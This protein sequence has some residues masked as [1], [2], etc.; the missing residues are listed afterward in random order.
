MSSV[1]TTEGPASGQEGPGRDGCIHDDLL[2]HAKHNVKAS[3]EKIRKPVVEISL[4]P[5]VGRRKAANL[6]TAILKEYRRKRPA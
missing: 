5:F 6:S 2:E 3:L 1:S 4:R